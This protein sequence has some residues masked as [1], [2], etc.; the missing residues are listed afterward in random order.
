MNVLDKLINISNSHAITCNM[1]FNG[2]T[3]STT[4][5]KEDE[6]L[7]IAKFIKNDS[8]DISCFYYGYDKNGKYVGGVYV[9]ILNRKIGDKALIEFKTTEKYRN[10]GNISVIMQDALHDIFINS[11]LDEIDLKQYGKSKIECLMFKLSKTNDAAVRVAE[12][13]GFDEYGVLTKEKYL[14]NSKKRL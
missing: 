5:N 4:K 8:D 6:N 9:S 2:L 11:V 1:F 7:F 14:N 13:F 3:L 10:K 12:K